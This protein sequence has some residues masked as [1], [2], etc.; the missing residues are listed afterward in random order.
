MAAEE[1]VS[2]KGDVKCKTYIKWAS[3]GSTIIFILSAI[4]YVVM[5]G[6]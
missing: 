3:S 1:E 2:D 6:I 5:V 4:A